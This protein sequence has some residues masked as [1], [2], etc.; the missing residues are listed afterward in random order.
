VVDAQSDDALE[1]A[2]M[3]LGELDALSVSA[4]CAGFAAFLP[5]LLKLNTGTPPAMPPLGNGLLVVCGSVNPTTRRQLDWAEGHGFTRLRLTPTQKLEACAATIPAI[6]AA[7]AQGIDVDGPVPPDT[8]FS[9]ARG[10]WYDIV[11]AMYHDQ[12]HIPLKLLG[13][14]YNRERGA[15]DA[16]DGV[17]IT[18]GLPIVRKWGEGEGVGMML[19]TG[20]GLLEIVANAPDRLGAGGLRHLAFEVENTDVCLEAVREA[21]Y[22]VT[23]EPTDIVI[24][25]EPPYPA[26]IAFCIGPVGEEVEFFQVK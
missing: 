12:G 23:M 26:R 2:G 7:R 13:F 1:R 18:L 21:G 10:G 11:V 15:W 8:V 24:A 25:S 17:N 14:V 6:E 9:K 4:G 16:V 20:A 19:D 22:K 5:A 3:R